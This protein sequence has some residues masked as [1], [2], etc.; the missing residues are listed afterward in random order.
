VGGAGQRQ[1]KAPYAR[2]PKAD[3]K[4]FGLGPGNFWNEQWWTQEQAKLGEQYGSNAVFVRMVDGKPIDK[5]PTGAIFGGFLYDSGRGAEG[6]SPEERAAQA[7]QTFINAEEWDYMNPPQDAQGRPLNQFGEPLPEG[8]KAFNNYGQPYYGPGLGGWLNEVN[9]K[10][11]Q[12]VDF[13]EMGQVG[14]RWEVFKRALWY[15]LGGAGVK[16]LELPAQGVEKI[17]AVGQGVEAAGEGSPL[18]KIDPYIDTQK[19]LRWSGLMKVMRGEKPDESDY[20]ISPV[21]E[22]LTNIGENIVVDIQHSVSM[23]RLVD[24]IMGRDPATQGERDA[25][26]RDVAETASKEGGSLFGDAVITIYDT[27]ALIATGGYNTLRMATAPGT[28]EEKWKKIALYERSSMVAYSRFL[29]PAIAEEMFR[30]MEAGEDPQFIA[31]Q[32]AN[33]WAELAGQ[34]VFDPL[35]INLPGKAV[36][37][38]GYASKADALI[39]LVHDADIVAAMTKLDDAVQLTNEAKKLNSIQ[40]LMRADQAYFDAMQGLSK[41]SSKYAGGV[42]EA[43]QA[44]RAPSLLSK[45]GRKGLSSLMFTYTADARQQIAQGMSGQFMDWLITRDTVRGGALDVNKI[46]DDLLAMTKR[47]SGNADEA[48]EGL[49]TLLRSNPGPGVSQSAR[50]LFSKVGYDTSYMLRNMMADAEGLYDPQTFLKGLKAAAGEHGDDVKGVI[51]YA[52][53]KIEAATKNLYPSVDDGKRAFESLEAGKDVS[54]ATRNMAEWYKALPEGT[55]S[56]NG[57]NNAALK[58][59]GPLNRFFANVYMGFSPAYAFRNMLQNTLHVAVDY[60]AKTGWQVMAGSLQAGWNRL[61]GRTD[62]LEKS[63]ITAGALQNYKQWTGAE[64]RIGKAGY[65]ATSAPGAVGGVG[66]IPIS[67]AFED[68]AS[69]IVKAKT[70]RDVMTKAMKPGVIFPDVAPLLAAGVPKN[71]V[72]LLENAIIGNYG[73]VGKAY[74]QIVAGANAGFLPVFRDMRNWLSGADVKSL[75]KFRWADGGNWMDELSEII[76]SA[77]NKAD[78]LKGVDEYRSRFDDFVRQAAKE[79]SA[80]DPKDAELMQPAHDNLDA[81]GG[82]EDALGLAQNRIYANSRSIQAVDNAA[83]EIARR[84]GSPFADVES[85]SIFP[86]RVRT[87]YNALTGKI[88]QWSDTT[89]GKAFSNAVGKKDWAKAWKVLTEKVGATGAAPTTYDDFYARLLEEFYSQFPEARKLIEPG[90]DVSR[91]TMGFRQA[92]WDRFWRPK[93]A[94]IWAKGRDDALAILEKLAKDSGTGDDLVASARNV[95]DEARK[96]DNAEPLGNGLYYVPE[97]GK[98]VPVDTGERIIGQAAKAGPPPQFVSD[99]ETALGDTGKATQTSQTLF[100]RLS[101]GE[102]APAEYL[103]ELRKLYA[104]DADVLAMVERNIPEPV[105]PVHN[106]NQAPTLAQAFYQQRKGMTDLLDRVKAGLDENWGKMQPINPLPTNAQTAMQEWLSE[107]ASRVDYTRLKAM[108][109]ADLARDFTMLS[110]HKNYLDLTLGYI[111]PYQYWYSRTYANW[112]TRA[113]TNPGVV[114]GYA[115]YKDQLAKEHADLPEWWRYNLSTNELFGL[116]SEN[117]LFF[118]L[119]ATLWP[120]N[121]ITGVD[122]NDPYKRVNWW[123]GALDSMG[124]FGP[125]LWTPLQMAVAASLS[126]Q[127]ET[128]AGARWANRLIPQTAQIKSLTALLGIGPKGGVELDPIVNYAFDNNGLDPYERKRVGRALSQLVEE[129][130]ISQEEAIEAAR[131]Q[132]GDAWEDAM[133]YAAE[134]RAPGQ[135]AG[136]FLGVGFKGRRESD[137]QIDRFYQDYNRLWATYENVSPDEFNRLLD[138]LHT[139]YPFMDT[140]LLSRKGGAERDTTYTYSVLSRIPPGQKD[141]IMEMIGIDPKLVDMFYESKGK[142]DGWVETDKQRFMTGM[143]DLGA[144]LAIPQDATRQEWTA[145]RGAYN[146]MLS[147]A[148]TLYGLD[149]WDKVDTYFGMKGETE[150][151]NAA[152]EAYL[153]A[154]PIVGEALDWK[155]AIVLSN[156]LLRDYYGGID[157]TERFLNGQMY[158]QIETQLGAEIWTTW[159]EYW[160]LKDAGQY[161]EAA[162]YFKAHPEL[163]AYGEIKKGYVNSINQYLLRIGQRIK[164]APK[165]AIRTD[166][167]ELSVAQQNLLGELNAP[168]EPMFTWAQWQSILPDPLEYILVSVYRGGRTELPES[169]LPQIEAIASQLGITAEQLTAQL[170]ASL[171]ELR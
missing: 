15:G 133:Q 63:P 66:A 143:V 57:W 41:A 136:F 34:L 54:A 62:Y 130:R 137:I 6:L 102:I 68:A 152:A 160:L 70:V 35:N 46:A 91:T 163:K 120:L 12:D 16:A 19:R 125:S 106:P 98:T 97:M 113:V 96:W 109:I 142:M 89:K 38:A 50:A 140:L 100:V 132:S 145:A 87:E 37:A 67:N 111:L 55:K 48:A 165:P 95:A 150:A 56:L 134:Q 49:N 1:G 127:G 101:K 10:V 80:L 44:A 99:I 168:A 82:G 128:D 31:S 52:T 7:P 74:K 141:D 4:R 2:P 139:I 151:E 58:V 119:E 157:Q 8:A 27:L 18:P 3:S 73:N 118:N 104:A 26:R 77:E 81:F 20:F 72:D 88:W 30:R 124:K 122:F 155:S 22:A 64:M 103:T 14:G 166:T 13:D 149:I 92:I 146:K 60:D 121:G 112:L 131:M 135:L 47:A 110:Y 107:A 11:W 105:F 42:S 65:V 9:S 138:E 116:D 53:K 169:A 90:G 167:G 126:A 123:T 39:G 75:G 86:Q 17:V 108:K 71:F 69:V 51:A 5:V 93:G 23:G 158:D 28:V 36:Q 78:A 154:N 162:A 164:N 25:A 159:S 61:K 153:Q 21:A 94:E 171:Q 148:R 79:P 161:K 40:D 170:F 115:K 144:L 59:V 33:P 29:E 117:P 45:T 76:G 114:A 83:K 32:Y 156:T 85:L 24:N 147:E 129:G 43:M 84:S